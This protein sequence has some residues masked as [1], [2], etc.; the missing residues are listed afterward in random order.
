MLERE[1][2]ARIPAACLSVIPATGHLSPLE[3]PDAVAQTLRKFIATLAP[4]SGA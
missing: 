4:V 2:A 3:A 1:V